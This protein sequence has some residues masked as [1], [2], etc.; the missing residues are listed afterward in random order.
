MFRRTFIGSLLAASVAGAMTFSAGAQMASD[1]HSSHGSHD[2]HG[3]SHE[4]LTVSGST[5]VALNI[6]APNMEALETAVDAHVE[7]VANGSG[8]G[9]K[10]LVQGRAQVAMTS[11]P[12]GDVKV[13][14]E[15][16]NP[17]LLARVDL[18]EHQI[19]NAKTLFIV[20]RDN[21]VRFLSELQMRQIWTGKITNWKD[22]GGPDKPI[23]VVSTREGNGIRTIVEKQFLNGASV[24]ESA[25]LFAAPRQITKV[26]K[27]LPEAIGF[28]NSASITTDVAIIG[29]IVIA[30]PLNLVTIGEPTPVVERFRA[31]A[32][33]I[34]SKL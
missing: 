24:T 25:R 34:G 4:V 13:A 23:V 28:G 33:K 30:Q 8:N 29:G 16:E 32:A 9:I 10:D 26:V 19:G 20:H 18:R 12:L 14:I 21:P 6:V 27:Q 17:G 7:V 15:R 2:S 5:T 11:A 3:Q 1:T 22:V 31:E